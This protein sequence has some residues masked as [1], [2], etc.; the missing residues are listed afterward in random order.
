[1]A[2]K[3]KCKNLKEHLLF[4]LEKNLKRFWLIDMYKYMFYE[5]D[6]LLLN[7][8]IKFEN[9]QITLEELFKKLNI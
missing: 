6:V 3:Q 7:E 8:I 1:M 2:L 4:G 9:F 5:N